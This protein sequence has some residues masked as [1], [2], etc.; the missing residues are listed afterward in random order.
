MMIRDTT[1]NN[2]IIGFQLSQR[3]LGVLTAKYMSTE[4]SFSN[5]EP[6]FIRKTKLTK[7]SSLSTNTCTF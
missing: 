2:T 3:S 1:N 6:R 5:S 7:D 4:K